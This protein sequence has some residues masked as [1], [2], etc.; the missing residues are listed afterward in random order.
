MVRTKEQALSGIRPLFEAK[1]EGRLL[2][3][4]AG[5][6]DGAAKAELPKQLSP[7]LATLSARLPSVGS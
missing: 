3:F 2:S 5:D 4:P 6:L 7:Q 1:R